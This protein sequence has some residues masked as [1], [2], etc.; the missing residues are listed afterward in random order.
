MA[1]G[2]AAFWPT[3]LGKLA[4]WIGAAVIPWAAIIAAGH[5]YLM[6]AARG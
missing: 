6:I 5:Y 2:P 4:V 3:S 1:Q